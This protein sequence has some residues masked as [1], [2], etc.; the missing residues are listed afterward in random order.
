MGGAKNYLNLY[1]AAARA[2]QRVASKPDA[3]PFKLGGPA[4]TALY[5]NWIKGLIKYCQANNYRLDFLSWHHYSMNVDAFRKDIG[6]ASRWLYDF[7]EYQ[8]TE[9]TITEWGHDSNVHPGYDSNFGA[10]HTL[11]VATELEGYIQRAFVF[12]IQ[13]GKDPTG[14]EYW[15][16]WGM[17]THESFGAKPKPRFRALKMLEQLGNQRLQITGKGTWVKALATTNG[18]AIQVLVVNYDPASANSETVPLKIKNLVEPSYKVVIQNLD[19]NPRTQV[20]SPEGLELSL[21]IPLG[22]NQASMVTVT[23]NS[24]PSGDE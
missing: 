11:A 5:E 13:D 8:N 22:P 24:R 9:L 14:K 21:S 6:Q 7:P 16:R 3:K 15:G 17:F 18:E 23:P 4:T 19:G 1:G 12:E 2:A 20:L 10:I